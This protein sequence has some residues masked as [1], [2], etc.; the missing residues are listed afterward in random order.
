MN[1]PHVDPAVGPAQF[2]T[3]DD[4]LKSLRCMK[5][6]KVA[7]PSGVAAET[8]KAAPDICCKIIADLMNTIVCEG[9]VPA[10][11]SDSII[12]SLFKGKGDA[13]DQ[14]NYCALK[15]TNH[16]LKVI[17]RVVKKIIR[18]TVNI[19]EMQFGFCQSRGTTDAIFI[20]RQLQEKHLTKRRKLYMAF[21]N[22]EKAFKKCLEM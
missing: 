10:D 7:G 12:D 13:L 19:G 21:V 14:T 6:G 5:N 9:K 18:E 2:I 11:L 22:L 20:L 4:V 17:E 1:L 8:L 3:P 16:V 15:L